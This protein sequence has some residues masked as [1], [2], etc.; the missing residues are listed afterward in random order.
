MGDTGFREAVNIRGQI[1]REAQGI[2][3]RA[4]KRRTADLRK[5]ARDLKAAAVTP[6]M[7]MDYALRMLD[8]ENEIDGFEIL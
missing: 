7:K 6:E 4:L 8:A 2:S 3:D 5:A 1:Y